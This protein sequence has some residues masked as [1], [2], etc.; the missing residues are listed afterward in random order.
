[1]N[2]FLYIAITFIIAAIG[3]LCKYIGINNVKAWLLYA[4]G[5]AEKDLGSGTGVLKLR[6]VY[7]FFI[8]RFPFL[9]KFVTFDYFAKLVDVALDELK[10]L[11]SKNKDVKDYIEK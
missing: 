8:L 6:R 1:M 3:F 2:Y 10:A 5:E 4:C 7:D 9:S 11:L